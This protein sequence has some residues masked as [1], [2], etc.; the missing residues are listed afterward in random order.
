MDDETQGR[1][2]CPS[3]PRVVDGLSNNW[4]MKIAPE[5]PP[6]INCTRQLVLID[7]AVTRL[8]CQ[9]LRLIKARQPL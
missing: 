8:K 7:A 6:S 5:M 9:S 3:K 2:A 4:A 1:V